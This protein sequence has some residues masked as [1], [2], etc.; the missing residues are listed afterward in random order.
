MEIIAMA[1]KPGKCHVLNSCP[2]T[3]TFTLVMNCIALQESW[4]H[5]NLI[6][7]SNKIH[8]YIHVEIDLDN[9]QAK[10]VTL[11]SQKLSFASTYNGNG[12]AICTTTRQQS[13]QIL[14]CRNANA[15][16]PTEKV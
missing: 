2:P 9:I 6:I 15:Y 12:M 16:S 11:A 10:L 14:V 5:H 8:K 13:S 1:T 7:A 3:T 4:H